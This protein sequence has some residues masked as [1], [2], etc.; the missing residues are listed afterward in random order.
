MAI[1]TIKAG[2]EDRKKVAILG[3]LLLVAAVVYFFNSSGT[4]ENEGYTPPAANRPAAV[5]NARSSATASGPAAGRRNERTLREFRPTLKP[6]KPEDR[7]DPTT[8]DPTLRMDLLAKVQ[9]VKIDGAH[10][11]IFE[12]GTQPPRP[13]EVAK[14]N[15]AKPK[16]PNPLAAVVAE[17]KP[18]TDATPAKPVAP[19]VPLKF[20]GYMTPSGQ[21]TKRA[22]FVEGED[23]HVVHEGDT[24]K[25]R[26]KIVR[27]GVNSVVVEDTQFGSQQ[28][29]PL[30]EQSG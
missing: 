21:P 2:T 28:T 16:V 5:S 27:I 29:L 15:A 1:K 19:P 24:V 7:P 22:F 20:F 3:G 23:I 11:N 26:Y 6:R 18:Q 8:I 17:A 25:Q 10:R 12:F 9:G 4:P 30:E 14:A 13:A